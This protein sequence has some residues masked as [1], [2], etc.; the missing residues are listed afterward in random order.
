MASTHPTTPASAATSRPRW[1]RLARAAR[2]ARPGSAPSAPS[3][4]RTTRPSTSPPSARCRRRA[5]HFPCRPQPLPAPPLSPHLRA[6]RAAYLAPIGRGRCTAPFDQVAHAQEVTA[7]DRG[8]V[9]P[10]EEARPA[11]QAPIPLLRPHQEDEAPHRRSID[12]L[13]GRVS[14]FPPGWGPARGFALGLAARRPA[15]N[16]ALLSTSPLGAEE[17]EGGAKPRASL[18]L[19]V[20]VRF[21]VAGVASG[22]F[23]NSVKIVTYTAR[24]A[25]QNRDNSQIS[26]RWCFKKRIQRSRMVECLAGL[27][28][29]DRSLSDGRATTWGGARAVRYGGP[30]RS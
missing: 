29:Q 2:R 25:A 28:L 13:L 9:L 14:Y 8:G 27:G 15:C 1:Q 26:G 30:G 7:R 23:G 11:N 6:R 4:T 20:G 22:T 10:R 19:W 17:G 16:R 18:P 12:F 5:A 21:V 24:C 3:T